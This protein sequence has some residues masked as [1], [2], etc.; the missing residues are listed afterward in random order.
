MSIT[1]AIDQLDPLI[2]H[3]M[4]AV[5]AGKNISS[6]F[7]AQVRISTI[8]SCGASRNPTNIFEETASKITR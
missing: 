6:F 8:S 7:D 5:Y 1:N 3:T 2:T 4:E